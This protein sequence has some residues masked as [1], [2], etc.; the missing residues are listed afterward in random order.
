MPGRP[1]A[2]LILIPLA[3]SG[4]AQ[5]TNAEPRVPAGTGAAGPACPDKPAGGH[6]RARFK[7]AVFPAIDALREG[8]VA[9]IGSGR[10]ADIVVRTMAARSNTGVL[11][12]LRRARAAAVTD[13][14]LCRS[15]TPPIDALLKTVGELG[16]SLRT[17]RPDAAA[18]R[19]AGAEADALRAAAAK[20]GLRNRPRQM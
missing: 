2:A 18:A 19:T 17:T 4:C 5:A 15:L 11:A 14:V 20:L 13:P 7:A 6:A 10:G 3:L 1:L 8:V 12:S 16:A 9:P